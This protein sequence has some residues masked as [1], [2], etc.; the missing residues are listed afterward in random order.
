MNNE[1]EKDTKNNSALKKESNELIL[2]GNNPKAIDKKFFMTDK[3]LLDLEEFTKDKFME[4]KNQ[5][6]KL[7][8]V[9]PDVNQ[10][11]LGKSNALSFSSYRDKETMFSNNIKNENNNTNNSSF[12]K[13]MSNK[14]KFLNQKI[15]ENKSARKKLE[16]NKKEFDLTCH[17]F[18]KNKFYNFEQI[19]QKIFNSSCKKIK[20][21][22]NDEK[23]KEKEK[24]KNL[25]SPRAKEFIKNKIV[26]RND[27]NALDPKKSENNFFYEKKKWETIDNIKV[28]NNESKRQKNRNISS[29]NI[30]LTQKNGES[31]SFNEADIKLVYL[32]KFVN[33]K[34]PY[35]P[36]EAF[37]GEKK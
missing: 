5:I 3:K 16:S 30:Y 15:N 1:Y 32:N 6:D 23:E 37:L 31:V 35:A 20:T 24:E 27:I 10:N 9:N 34:L 36:G 14:L 2:Y 26:S 12:T 11:K 21:Y 25:A 29:G 13:N 8:V 4:I 28:K 18:R 22:S 19:S 17:N 7:K 33:K